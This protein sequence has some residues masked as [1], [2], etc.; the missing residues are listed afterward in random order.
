MDAS[1]FA[2]WEDRIAVRARM[3]WCD[4]GEP[5]GGPERF[6]DQARELLAIEEN[7]DAATKPVTEGPAAEPLVAVE[8]QGEFPTLTDQGEERTDPRRG[9]DWPEPH[10]AD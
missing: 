9:L 3:M 5:E 1:E 4:A 6:L 2:A 10:P 8:N 7:P